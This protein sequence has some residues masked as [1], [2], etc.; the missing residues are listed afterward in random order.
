[1][2]FKHPHQKTFLSYH[3]HALTDD[4]YILLLCEQ[5]KQTVRCLN[6]AAWGFLKRE[7]M[8]CC[9]SNYTLRYPYKNWELVSL[10]P[11][12]W[13]YKRTIKHGECVIL[14]A[15]TGHRMMSCCVST[16]CTSRQ[17]VDPAQCLDLPSGIQWVVTNGL[18]ECVLVYQYVISVRLLFGSRH[19]SCLS[20]VAL[21]SECPDP[22]PRFENLDFIF[23][24]KQAPQCVTLGQSSRAWI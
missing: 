1:M 7:R 9:I 21:M 10:Y 5:E 14:Q 12:K 4:F 3:F 15:P 11:G 23:S 22:E 16:V 20:Y 8:S 13:G 19:T 17:C 6:T 24:S 18:Y 2:S